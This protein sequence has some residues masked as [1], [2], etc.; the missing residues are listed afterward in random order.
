[1]SFFDPFFE[2][3]VGFEASLNCDDMLEWRT[4]RT[5]TIAVAIHADSY[6]SCEFFPLAGFYLD[7]P[8]IN[9]H[10]LVFY[11]FLCRPMKSYLYNVRQLHTT[12]RL[13]IK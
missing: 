10:P 2:R 4:G 7:P 12:L 6:P 13:P 8:F 9:V 5:N 11:H 1:M 3:I